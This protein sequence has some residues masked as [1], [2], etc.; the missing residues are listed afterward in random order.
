MKYIITENQYN[1]LLEQQISF[2]PVNTFL[3]ANPKFND[4]IKWN[5]RF[6]GLTSDNSQITPEYT[7]KVN[8]YLAKQN[9]KPQ[10]RTLMGSLLNLVPIY[11]TGLDIESIID[12]IVT[13][14]NA[15]LKGGTLGLLVPFSYKAI[16]SLMG[17]FTEKVSG[18]D[19]ADYNEKKMEEVINMTQR[20]KEELFK[21]YGYGGYDKWVKAGKPKL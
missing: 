14:N 20:E 10:Q 15:K 13:G 12:G 5:K 2:V 8:E 16:T 7:K 17:Y 6:L 21:R 9:V 1:V 11:E 3:Q 4:V 18:K 19:V